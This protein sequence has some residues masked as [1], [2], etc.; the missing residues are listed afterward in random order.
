MAAVAAA[1]PWEFEAGGSAA[2]SAA[3]ANTDPTIGGNGGFGFALL[4]AAA[5]AAGG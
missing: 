1:E 3:A 4:P 2:S 5:V